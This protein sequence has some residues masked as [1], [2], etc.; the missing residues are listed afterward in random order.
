M[1]SLL[2]TLLAGL[3][4]P[5]L[6]LAQT[7]PDRV[8]IKLDE[9]L[10]LYEQGQNRPEKPAK[11]PRNHTV[12]AVD[13]NGRVILDKGEPTSAVFDASFRIEVLDDEGWVK[14]PLLPATVALESA[15]L[16]GA[17][18]P[19]VLEGGYYYLITNKRGAFDVKTRFATSVFTSEGS[20]GFSFQLV[21]SG[22]TTVELR[23]PADESLDF[24]VSNARLQEE[25]VEGGNRVVSATLP[26]TG[27]LAVSWQ[28][29]LP[30]A[31][32]QDPR[33]Y[34]EVYS[35]V[36]VGDG[37]LTAR[38]TIDHTILFAGVDS[39][40]VEIPEGMTLL[41]VQG[42]GIRDWTVSKGV[43]DV[44]L[45]YEAEGSY[46]L[47]LSMEK[48][49]GQGDQTATAPL[50]KP[51]NVERA[52]GWMG[53]E[54]RGNLEVSGGDAKGATPVDVRALPSAILGITGNPVLLGY[55]YLGTDAAIPLIIEEHDDVDVLVTLL[56][57]AVATT[58]WTRDGRR[59]TSVRYQVRNNR[60]QYLRLEMPPGAEL[61]SANV[62]GRA[63]QPARAADG[64]VM[65]PLVRSQSTGGSL[66]A[67]QVEV[68][69]VEQGDAAG[70]S[71]KGSFTA[72]LPKADAPT[73][74]VGWGVY[75]PSGAKL[76]RN[77]VEGTLRQVEWLSNPGQ[78]ANLQVIQT[79]TPNQQ[80]SAG[81]Q[82]NNGAMGSG[83]VPVPVTLPLEGT[84]TW[85]EKLLAVD[86]TLTVSY[87]YKGV[88]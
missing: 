25:R 78:A 17:E 86:E 19:M 70:E 24:T 75:A 23:V 74:Y 45:N 47:T 27:S 61:W 82:A 20:S 29:E 59:L 68:V 44:Q 50:P 10:K 1:R 67:F 2:P 87:E 30:Q 55:K 72:Q 69:Y 81:G 48:V 22:S 66:A 5:S 40:Q 65:V 9:F 31:E 7:E 6:A 79:A 14:V 11:P 41:D 36:G 38:A 57:Q 62:G 51:L 49:V 42:T 54:A 71:G 28:R 64:R 16:G 63:V 13:Y 88:D 3:L 84:P 33:V 26:A 80:R 77:S 37:L 35:L 32:Q 60:R 4:L 15:T 46:P 83:A 8:T 76:R 85:Y 21:P 58:M 56:D 52:K 43:L 34:A 12:S 18:A 73:T 39:L 53:V